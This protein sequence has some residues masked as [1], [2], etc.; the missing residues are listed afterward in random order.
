MW[1]NALFRLVRDLSVL[2]CICRAF[3]LDAFEGM[4]EYCHPRLC[5]EVFF[6]PPSLSPSIRSALMLAYR[7]FSSLEVLYTLHLTQEEAHQVTC[8]KNRQERKM[9]KGEILIIKYKVSVT[10]EEQFP[11]IFHNTVARVNYNNNNIL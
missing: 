8:K 3:V 2:I 7:Q 6:L 9:G 1:E 4:V 11:V 10:Y 5:G